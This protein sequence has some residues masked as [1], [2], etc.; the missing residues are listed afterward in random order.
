M[1]E[2]ATER[3][4]V[5]FLVCF[6]NIRYEGLENGPPPIEKGYGLISIKS[7]SVSVSLS[8]DGFQCN[9]SCHSGQCVFKLFTIILRIR[10][11]VS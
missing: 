9:H 6:L 5:F 11:I 7:V 8:H 4:Y 1:S 2:R 3:E 10:V